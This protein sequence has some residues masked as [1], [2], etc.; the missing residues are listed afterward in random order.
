MHDGARSHAP[1]VPLAAGGGGVDR[2]R[3]L[4]LLG[5]APPEEHPVRL[6]LGLGL[7][8]GVGVGVSLGLGLGLGSGLASSSPT[9]I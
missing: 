3:A 6:G 8:V 2:L 7:G 5:H 4:L 9:L 1:H